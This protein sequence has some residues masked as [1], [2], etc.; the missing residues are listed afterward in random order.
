MI[1]YLALFGGCSAHVHCGS[2]DTDNDTGGET[3]EKRDLEASLADTLRAATLNPTAVHCDTE[4]IAPQ[5][6]AVVTCEVELD[7]KKSYGIH[8]KITA[9][10]GDHLSFE[11]TW[12]LPHAVNARK[13][14][15]TIIAELARDPGVQ[16]TVDCREPLRSLPDSHVLAC[17]AVFDD[18]PHV[19][20]AR[21]DDELVVT[22]VT[23]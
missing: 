17:D 6:G 16:A 22:S 13:L 18:E 10:D 4:D 2:P 19:V 23:W 12:V 1:V 14:E 7:G 9:R 8:A 20:R 21:L 15:Q 3:V 5:V 11:N